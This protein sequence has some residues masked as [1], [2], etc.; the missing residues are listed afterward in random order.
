MDNQ[1]KEM[2][3]KGGLLSFAGVVLAQ[4][5]VLIYTPDGLLGGLALYAMALIA[6]FLREA[7]KVKQG[8]E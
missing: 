2:L 1:T 8:R 5:T 7:L 4:G 6:L 3:Q